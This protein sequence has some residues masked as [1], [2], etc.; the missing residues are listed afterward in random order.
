MFSLIFGWVWPVPGFSESKP[1]YTILCWG[2]GHVRRTYISFSKGQL[3][4][5]PAVY[6][7]HT[8]AQI[9]G[10]HPDLGVGRASSYD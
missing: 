9:S 6:R 3:S 5:T 4:K 7:L 2:F 10:L 8:H 1:L